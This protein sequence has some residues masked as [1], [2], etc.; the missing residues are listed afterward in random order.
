[1]G[2]EDTMASV[3]A[4]LYVGRPVKRVED[5][6]LVRGQGLY[7]QDLRLPGLAYL[8]FLR[9]PHAHARVR[10]IRTEQ[11][12]RTPGVISVAG[13]RDL[14][15]LRPLPAMAVLPGLKISVCPYLADE[16]VDATGVPVAAVVAETPSLARDGAELIQVDYEP[17]GAVA[18]AD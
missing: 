13:A 10:A 14:G 1:R 15:P 12:L 4:L 17:L 8:A 7:V 9:S 6:R 3:G 16:T 2:L 5:P 11:P 18:E